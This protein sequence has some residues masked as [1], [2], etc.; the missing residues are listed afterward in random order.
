M[1]IIYKIVSPKNK[2]YIGRTNDFNGRM[3]QHKHN[4]LVDKKPNT[5][6]KAIRKYGWDNFT[7]EIIC[8]VDSVNAQKVEEE[9]ILAYNSVRKG[10]NDTYSGGGGDLWKG[11][12]DTNEYMEYVEKMRNIN[13]G[14][15]NPMFGKSHSDNTKQLQKEK[16][17]GRYSLDW[18][19]NRNGPEDGLRL[20]EERR[21]WLKNRNLKKDVNGRFISSYK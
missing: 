18:F 14:Q 10:Y 3:A 20:Y 15:K 1:D 13:I 16:A 19:I 7:K 5:L 8:E 11:R 2:V 17:K 12:R 9:F 21:V 6:Y 4:A